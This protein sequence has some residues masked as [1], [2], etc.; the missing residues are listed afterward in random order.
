MLT[1]Q[2]KEFLKENFATKNDV[3]TIVDDALEPVKKDL[4]SIKKKLDTTITH[5]DIQL[6]Y[7]H[8]RLIQVEENIGVKPP[9]YTI[10]QT[11][12]N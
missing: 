2:D 9:P 12:A 5:F 3:K 7:H 4:K 11:S 8:R 1:K 10:P 6:N